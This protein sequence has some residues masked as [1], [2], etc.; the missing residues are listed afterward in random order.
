MH[1]VSHWALVFVY[2]GLAALFA[3]WLEV[4]LWMI[5]A[6]ESR[7]CPALLPLLTDI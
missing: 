4:S 7:D 3:S 6:G 5:A 2:L 1:E